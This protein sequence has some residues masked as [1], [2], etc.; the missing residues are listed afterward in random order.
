MTIRSK[1][2]S[3]ISGLHLGP[4]AH[5]RRQA[6]TSPF[7]SPCISCTSFPGNERLQAQHSPD[8]C[9]I[10]KEGNAKRSTAMA[11]SATR[12]SREGLE[13][14]FQIGFSF[15]SHTHLRTGQFSGLIL[16]SLMCI[17]KKTARFGATSTELEST[18]PSYVP[19]DHERKQ[20]LYLNS[21]HLFIQHI[22][23]EHLLH[24]RL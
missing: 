12:H 23:I 6:L 1:H 19:C 3:K 18:I 13:T 16:L 4:R 11:A 15:L 21:I 8:L 17:V 2:R 9:S 10:A 5:L 14:S 7:L 24:T 20:N 22:F